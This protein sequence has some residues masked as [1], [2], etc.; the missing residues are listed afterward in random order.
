MWIFTSCSLHRYARKLVFELVSLWPQNT[1]LHPSILCLTNPQVWAVLPHHPGLKM[2]KSIWNEARS[3]AGRGLPKHLCAKLCHL[4]PGAL[5][6]YVRLVSPFSIL[7]LRNN[8]WMLRLYLVVL[9]E[10][11]KKRRE[12]KRK[13]EKASKHK[14]LI[15]CQECRR[16]WVHAGLPWLLFLCSYKAMYVDG[17]IKAM[18]P[19]KIW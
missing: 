8:I 18:L 15:F 6:L 12:E 1:R 13:N 16:Q 5:C 2:V 7:Q 17:H 9:W 3:W 14:S 19:G 4:A 10:R 11:K